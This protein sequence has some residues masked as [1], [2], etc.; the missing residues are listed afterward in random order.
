[1]LQ[2]LIFFAQY[3]ILGNIC[4]KHRCVHS[5]YYIHIFRFS[6][7]EKKK[8]TSSQKYLAIR[9]S[10][11]IIKILGSTLTFFQI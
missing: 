11:S 2:K 4:G 1:M 5:A 10:N 9:F 7:G 3:G 6:A 8:V